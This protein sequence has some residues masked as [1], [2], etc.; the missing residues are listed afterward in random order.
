MNKTQMTDNF[1]VALGGQ[2]LLEITE[3]CCTYTVLKGE[4][5]VLCSGKMVDLIETG[6]TLDTSFWRGAMAVAWTDC[7]LQPVSQQPETASPQWLSASI[8]QGIGDMGVA[9]LS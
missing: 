1:V 9:L 5:L 7:I 2:I 4:V 6:E 3:A 8:Y